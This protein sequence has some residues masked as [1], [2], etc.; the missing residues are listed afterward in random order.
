MTDFL[1]SQYV[2][3]PTMRNSDTSL[4]VSR[5][6]G[7]VGGLP[8]GAGPGR[9]D[10]A[11]PAQSVM[12]VFD[13]RPFNASDVYF[14]YM[15][16]ISYRVPAGFNMILREVAANSYQDTNATIP[17]IASSGLNLTVQVNGVNVVLSDPNYGL[18]STFKAPVFATIQEGSLL[19][20][21][22]IANQYLSPSM[23]NVLRTSNLPAANS[24][25]KHIYGAGVF[26]AL[27]N[28]LTSDVYSTDGINWSYINRPAAGTYI[29]VCY[30][31]G[32]FMMIPSTM[33]NPAW[34][35]LFSTNGASWAPVGNSPVIAGSSGALITYGNGAFVI[36]YSAA[37]SILGTLVSTDN[38]NTWTN[39]PAILG[40]VAKA[41]SAIKYANGRFV[42]T[43]STVGEIYTSVD[44]I[45]WTINAVAGAV[46]GF[47]GVDYGSLGFIA[48][49]NNGGVGAVFRST[50]G[51]TWTSSAL[52]IVPNAGV[53]FKGVA[54]EA[55]V[56]YIASGVAAKT[57]YSVDGVNWNTISTTANGYGLSHG[58]GLIFETFVGVGI[59]SVFNVQDQ[60]TLNSGGLKMK[61]AI[62][63][64]LV[65]SNGKPANTAVYG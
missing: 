58:N 18:S 31:G 13:S 47:T 10:N 54:Y 22:V 45:T 7:N 21:R 2:P 64:Q 56:Y 48:A 36:V 24:Y 42:M 26:V 32:L 44:G 43:A 63:G 1:Q 33:A 14:E 65:P 20:G 27:S 38:G 34:N 59:G 23:Y 15:D 5:Q 52:P 62:T 35:I 49:A 60:N 6:S 29:D 28:N 8:F 41:A 4:D 57:A 61:Y 55:G 46:G 17:F 19:T 25:Q 53:T 40:A 37:G 39:T 30:G 3:L 16:L 11:A 51:L 9:G 50:D 12:P